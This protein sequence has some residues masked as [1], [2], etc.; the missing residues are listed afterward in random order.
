MKSYV[1]LKNNYTVKTI[2]K[3]FLNIICYYFGAETSKAQK[4]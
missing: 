3:K 4:Q 2:D 1:L